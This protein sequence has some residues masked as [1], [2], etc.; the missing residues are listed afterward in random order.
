MKDDSFIH[1]E[2]PDNILE[3]LHIQLL[4]KFRM[5]NSQGKNLF[6]SYMSFGQKYENELLIIGR[7]PSYWP[8]EFSTEEL[9][10]KGP[11]EVFKTKVLH[12]AKFGLDSLCPRHNK[13]YNSSLDP[14][15]GC[16]KEIVMKLGICR[17]ETNW[18]SYIAITYLYKIAYSSNR[19]LTDK[20]K[21][22]QFEYCREMFQLEL[23]ILKPKRV[24]FLTG[25]KYAQDFLELS[26][27]SGL[28]DC[29]CPLGV[30]DY[31][32]HKAKTVVS[33]HPKKYHRENLV[34]L[35]LKGF[36]D[37]PT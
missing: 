27:C 36:R 19:Y 14:F 37:N 15:W 17:D 21:M 25:M 23:S 9:N 26:D 13:S 22:M 12:H 32:F 33:V 4:K 11:V 18:S 6:C 20:P 3:S 10:D 28:K 29:V 30:F 34:D 35:I 24:L 1:T 7:Q 2:C 8:S 31:G 5:Y 16:T